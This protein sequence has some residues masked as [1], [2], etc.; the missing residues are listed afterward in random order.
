M[1]SHETK[2]LVI[3]VDGATF[4]VIKPLIHR[5]KLP[6][7]TKLMKEGVYGKLKSTIPPSSIPAWPSFMTGVNPAKHGCF[8]FMKRYKNE[9]YGKIITSKDIKAKTLWKILS[10]F[11]KKSIVINVTGT[12]PPE[13]IKGIIVSGLLTVEGRNYVYPPHLQKEIEKKGYR[14][15]VDNETLNAPADILFSELCKLEEKRVEVALHLLKKHEWDFFMVMLIGTDV[16]QHR[17]WNE[18]EII[19]MYYQKIDQLIGEILNNI[20]EDLNVFVVSDHGFGELKKYVY[21]N[22]WLHD[23]GLLSYKKVDASSTRES[24]IYSL[25]GR[26]TALSWLSKL[27]FTRERLIQMF[28]WL[29][30]HK[31]FVNLI[32]KSVKRIFH[33]LPFTNLD[34]DWSNTKVFLSSFF[35]TE[36]Q[37]LMI[38]LKGREPCGIVQPSEYE[39][40]RTFLIDRLRDLRDPETKEE[41][42]EG[43]FKKEEIYEGPFINEAPDIITLLKEG[44]KFS[45]GFKAKKVIV[46]SKGIEG[47]H[48]LF[49]IFIA[50]GLDIKRGIK[51]KNAQITDLMPTILHIFNISIPRNTDGR[52]LKEIFRPD[53][54]IGMRPIKYHKRDSKE[55]LRGRVKLLKRSLHE[56]L[57]S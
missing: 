7:I 48:R 17:L 37:S 31:E 24:K 39:E 34:I 1:K 19:A 49:G 52:V 26:E 55:A 8:D 32:P 2:V 9:Y 25:K 46:K 36:S 51:T 35:G 56:S 22:K 16:I 44:Y 40:M 29:L 54:E 5:G 27:G 15:F 23:L 6:V 10:E 47:A 38:N 53:S 13:K 11:D 4:D 20:S 12:F 41:I 14:I 21:I 42:F 30:S 28:G 45:Y 43:I 18:K 57:D 33:K 3:G 50:H